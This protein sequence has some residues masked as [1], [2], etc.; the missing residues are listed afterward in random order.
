MKYTIPVITR[1]QDNGDGGFTTYAYNT[2]D[3]LIAD[4]P[5]SS[6]YKKVDGKYQEV[7]VELTPEER[8]GIL[9]EDDPYE[10]GYIGKD[11]IEIEV[12][13]DGVAKLAKPLSF[14]ALR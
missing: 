14:H 5:N 11:S 12:G 8:A 2:E 10:N 4:H 6:D 1:T 9:N 7:K 13:E 3:E